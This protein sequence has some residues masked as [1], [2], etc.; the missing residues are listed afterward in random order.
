MHSNSWAAAA[1][2]SKTEGNDEKQRERAAVG[3]RVCAAVLSQDNRVVLEGWGSS[4][5]LVCHSRCE[6]AD[7]PFSV[8]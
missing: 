8:T 1:P 7:F 3:N 5:G 4:E 2:C 6:P